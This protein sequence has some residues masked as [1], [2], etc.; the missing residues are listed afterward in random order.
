MSGSNYLIQ[1]PPQYANQLMLGAQNPQPV[2]P[3]VQ[4]FAVYDTQPAEAPVPE[5]SSPE[6][7]NYTN[8]HTA[9]LDR[10]A[11][12]QTKRQAGLTTPE[13]DKEHDTLNAQLELLRKLHAAQYAALQAQV[14][15]DVQA[16]MQGMRGVSG[17]Q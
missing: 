5:D 3:L 2:G 16:I 11:F 10:Q 9:M 8:S 1:G 17:G 7:Q 15:N 4:P 14:P 6:P 12:L 13:E